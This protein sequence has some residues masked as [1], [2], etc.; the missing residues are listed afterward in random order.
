[1]TGGEVSLLLEHVVELGAL[2][3]V[4]DLADALTL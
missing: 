2:L 4:L 1:M 3:R